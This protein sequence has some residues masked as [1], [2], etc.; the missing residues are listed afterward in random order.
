MIEQRALP[1]SWYP[2]CQSK[3]VKKKE[4]KPVLFNGTE[5][6]L[7]RGVDG[8]L[9][10]VSR[11]CPHM[12]TDL[13]NGKIKGNCVECPLH[14]W[15]FNKDGECTKMPPSNLKPFQVT[16][17]RLFVS[18]KYG[19]IFIFWGETPLFDI[20]QFTGIESPVYS[21][22]RV[23]YLENTYLA[24]SL[25]GFDVWHFSHVHHRAVSN[26]YKIF[27]NSTFHIGISLRTEVIESSLYDRLVKLMGLGKSNIQIDYYG[28]NLI[29]VH[30]TQT[31]HCALLALLPGD[32]DET[33]TLYFIVAYPQKAHTFATKILER[34]KVQFM[35][36]VTFIFIKPD[37]P[38]QKNMR[39]K[40]GAL[41]I[42]D[43][44]ILDFWDYWEKLPRY[45][46]I[47]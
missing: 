1:Q 5:W 40:K 16:T 4:L 26:D 32:S 20:P 3:E 42:R 30:S 34:L 11:F 19:L 25:N 43:V 45:P 28:G 22:P 24:V 41:T 33:C 27:S 47:T 14:E 12:G 8:A 35:R 39:P 13:A 10:V 37:I 9:G 21:T 29:M 31:G 44:A 6:L 46:H 15:Q 38:V 17:S 7:F 36:Y 18:E 23:Q 2:L